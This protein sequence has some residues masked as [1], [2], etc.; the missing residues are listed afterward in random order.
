MPK[1]K[2]GALEKVDADLYVICNMK[3]LGLKQSDC[4]LVQ[5]SSIKSK[6]IHCE[7]FLA[8]MRPVSSDTIQI[9]C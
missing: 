7:H 3:V 9:L 8:E 5:I 1:R 2:L 6:G 4:I